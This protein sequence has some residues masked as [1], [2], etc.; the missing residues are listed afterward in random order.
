MPRTPTEMRDAI[1]RRVPEK[2]GNTVE[3]WVELVQHPGLEKHMQKIELLKSRGVG[4]ST[5]SVLVQL[6]EGDVFEDAAESE[7]LRLQYSGDKAPLLGIYEVLRAAATSMGDDVKIEARKGYVAFSRRRQFA[8]VRPS[9]K[10]RV[11]LGLRL[12]EVNPWGRLVEARNLGSGMIDRKVELTAP[13]EIDA[14]V[15]ARLRQAYSG[16]V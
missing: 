16:A 4:H 8:V 5:A 15:L 7:L 9:T 3:Y 6:A 14:E 2:T 13:G 10:A 1:L 12:A 11:D